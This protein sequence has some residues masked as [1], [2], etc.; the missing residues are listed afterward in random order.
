MEDSPLSSLLITG[1]RLDGTTLLL[2]VEGADDTASCPA[3]GELARRVHAR[4]QRSPRDLPWRGFAVRLVVTVRRFCCD[5]PACRRKTFAEGFGTA[6]EHRRRF[7]ADVRRYLQDLSHAL[8]ARPGAR[9][10]DRSGAPASHDTLL[11][12]AHAMAAPQS[13]TP[14]ILGVDDLAL[15]RGCRYATLLVD[16]ETHRPIELLDGRDAETLA[17]WLRQHPGIA[18]IVRD[19]AGAYAEGANQGAPEANQIADR[20]HLAKNVTDAFEEVLKQRRW[21]TT[22][23]GMVAAAAPS[24]ATDQAAA[25]ELAAAEAAVATQGD[26]PGAGAPAGER[27]APAPPSTTEEQALAARPLSPTKQREA[28]QRAAREARWRQVHDLHAQGYSLRR[29]AALLGLHRQTVRRLLD[30]PAPPRNRREHPRSGGI[31]SPKL[32]PYTAYLQQ[33]W[34]EGCTTVQQLHRELVERGYDGSYT[35]LNVALRPWRS[36]RPPKPPK[37][38]RQKHHPRTLNSRRLRRLLT[39]PPERLTDEERVVVQGL[40]AGDAKVAAE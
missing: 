21:E 26:E 6:L 31:A 35:L 1:I 2:D 25:A 14:R 13:P 16:L 12:L 20:F 30:S 37:P 15:R 8:G 36:P 39:R 18:T 34:R 32:A 22:G 23:D 29:I 10:A 17:T 11:R 38:L 24:S 5:N 7:T 3:C 28:A 4:Y 27:L 19:R 40:L 33:R 9:L